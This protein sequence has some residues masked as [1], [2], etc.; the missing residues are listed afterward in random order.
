MQHRGKSVQGQEAKERFRGNVGC[1]NEL[2][3]SRRAHILT[4]RIEI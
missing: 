2:P 4:D 3:T 1:F